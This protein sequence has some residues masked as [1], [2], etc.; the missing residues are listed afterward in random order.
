M[1]PRRPHPERASKLEPA[2][3]ARQTDPPSL[4]VTRSW[5]V[6]W[7][8]DRTGGL[9]HASK[10]KVRARKSARGPSI[11]ACCAVLGALFVLIA[12]G[13]GGSGD[14]NLS[15]FRRCLAQDQHFAVFIEGASTGSDFALRS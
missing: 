9:T 11:T 5:R 1:H 10:P 12:G 4:T 3:G 6:R 13:C 15:D 2:A 14:L 7:L 8:L